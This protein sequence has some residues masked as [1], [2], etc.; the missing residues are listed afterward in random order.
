[1]MDS[2]TPQYVWASVAAGFFFLA[3][4]SLTTGEDAG[5]VSAHR[6]GIDDS[7]CA[8]VFDAEARAGNSASTTA[9][10]RATGIAAAKHTIHLAGNGRGHPRLLVLGGWRWRLSLSPCFSAC[11]GW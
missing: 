8:A 3:C 9:A 2:F 5:G 6:A 10:L 7:A 11:N 1:M 4:S